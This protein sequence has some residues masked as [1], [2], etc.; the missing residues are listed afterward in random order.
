MRNLLMDLAPK[1]LIG[2]SG[3]MAAA[4][5]MLQL[6]MSAVAWRVTPEVSAA[7]SIGED[8]AVGLDNLRLTQMNA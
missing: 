1:S 3:T 4:P 8:E 2:F 7:V 5:L 6:L